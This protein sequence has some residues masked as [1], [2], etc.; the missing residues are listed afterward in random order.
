[1]AQNV[2]PEFKPKYCKKTKTKTKKNPK[3][4]QKRIENT[5]YKREKN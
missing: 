5:K 4:N 2:D 1:V 3:P